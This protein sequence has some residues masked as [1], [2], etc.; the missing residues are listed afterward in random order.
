MP[1]PQYARHRVDLSQAEII[2]ALE[3]AGWEV[4]RH[5]PVDLLCRRR[6][7]GKLALIEAK[8]RRAKKSN[9]VL[10]DKRQRTQAEFCERTGTPYVTTAEEALRA[11]GEIT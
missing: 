4:F 10:L 2:E 5:L 11:L 1:R 8:T 7:D 9:Q 6:R 3:K